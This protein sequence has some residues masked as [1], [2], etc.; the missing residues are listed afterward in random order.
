MGRFGH[1]FIFTFLCAMTVLALAASRLTAQAPVQVYGYF[2]TRLEKTFETRSASGI[3]GEGSVPEWSYPFVNIMGQSRISDKIRVFFNLNGSKAAAVDIRNIWGEYSFSNAFSIRI[4]KI[5]RK[6]GLY[7]E[8]L[9]AVPTYYGIE[10]PELFDADHLMISRTTTAMVYG[11]CDLGGGSLQYSASTDNGEGDPLSSPESGA[12]P[13]AYD[14]RYTFGGGDYTVGTSGYTSGGR[15]LPNVDVGKGSPKSGVLP[16]MEFDHFNVMGAYAE[17]RVGAFTVQGEYW[18]SSHNAM[19]DPAKVVVI[20]PKA[21]NDN[22]LA[23]FLI[24]P[25]GSKTSLANVNVVA[26]FKVQTW[27]VRGGYSFETGIGEIGPYFQWDWYSNPETIANKTYGGDDEAGVADD[28]VFN[29][30]T[31]GVLYRPSPEIAV[32]FDQS[33]HFYK[34][35]GESVR[36][37]E[38][39]LDFS[40][41]F[42]L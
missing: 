26:N 8:I 36:Y 10:P 35:N 15:A 4:G 23:R 6:F 1:R 5:Y 13:F 31:L 39:R 20:A 28:G 33:F 3:V 32:K 9:D 30:S 34:Y 29:K 17:A 25:S 19:R 11:A 21:N 18:S 38:V 24:N 40:F 16:W 7:N 14:V 37:P 22:Q 42:G 12:V 41:T 27:Y 2:S